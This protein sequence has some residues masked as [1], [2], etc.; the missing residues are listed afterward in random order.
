M[1]KKTYSNLIVSSSPHI[2]SNM[3][4]SRIMATQ[5]LKATSR[6]FGNIASRIYGEQFNVDFERSTLNDSDNQTHVFR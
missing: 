4:T 1:D 6:Q 5:P 3:D 2:V